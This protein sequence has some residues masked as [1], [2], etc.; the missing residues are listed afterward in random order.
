MNEV[1]FAAYVAQDGL[2]R[3]QG[4][5]LVAPAEGVPVPEPGAWAA[6]GSGWSSHGD[7]LRQRLAGITLE[8]LDGAALPQAHD[9]LLLAAPLFAAGQG[10]P[11][12]ELLPLY[13]RNRVALTKAEQ[14]AARK[15]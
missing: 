5:A 14:D 6:A 2:A 11:A 13:L 4:E 15:G 10:V 8:P 3:L 9:A 1:Y 12:G 7:A